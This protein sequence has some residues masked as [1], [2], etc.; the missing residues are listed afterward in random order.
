MPTARVPVVF[1]HGLWL[2]T[3]SW[4]PWVELFRTAGYEPFNVGWPGDSSTAEETREH[5][6][7]LAGRSLD[8]VT[9]H[10]A[11]FIQSLDTKPLL[12]GHSFGGLIA[13]RLLGQG[14]A[15]GAVSI[16]PAQMRGVL[17]LPLV[18]LRNTLP[19]LGNPANYKRAVSLTPEQF[20]RAFANAVSEAE[21]NALHA[22]YAIPAPAR[23]LFEGALANLNPHTSARVDFNHAERGPLLLI[24]GGKDGT[25]PE[26]VV[27]AE[28]KLYRKAPTVNDYRVFADRG[29]S[30]TIDHGWREIA[31]ASLEWLASKGLDSTLSDEALWSQHAASPPFP[32]E[33]PHAG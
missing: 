1:I 19:V 6:E 3:D 12:V 5:P 21:S 20:H 2:H 30:L 7:R 26:V 10:Y 9:E 11:R 18:Q 29:H 31:E 28:H 24:A 25:V 17:P 27:R 4:K 22:Q 8:E 23:P 32:S 16:A 33:G 13:Q 15:A 14:L